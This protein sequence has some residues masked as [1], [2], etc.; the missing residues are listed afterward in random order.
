MQNMPIGLPAQNKI[1]EKAHQAVFK[2][3][4]RTAN[5]NNNPQ[6]QCKSSSSSPAW[7]HM[8]AGVNY[9]LNLAAFGSQGMLSTQHRQVSNFNAP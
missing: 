8:L 2:R 3:D 5:L 7:A 4:V 1:E 6:Q 9:E